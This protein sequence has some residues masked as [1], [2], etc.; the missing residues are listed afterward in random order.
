MSEGSDSGIERAFGLTPLQEGMLYHSVRQPGSGLYH[1]RSTLRLRGPLDP[2]AFRRAW[3]AA[4]ARHEAFRTIFAWE[5]LERPLQVVLTE[6][7]LE[8]EWLDW[9]ALPVGERERRWTALL[10]R[11]RSTPFELSAPPLMRLYVV[12]ETDGVHRLLWSVHHAVMDG[13]SAALVVGEVL[14]DYEAALAGEELS[15]ATAP[16]FAHFV[17]W[18]EAQDTE[19]AAAFW[20]HRLEG[21]TRATPLP[22][23]SLGASADRAHRSL[24]LGA[25]A[26]E[27]LVAA[28][29]RMRVTLS[30]MVSAAWACVLART[31]GEGDVVYGVTLSERPA[32]IPGI[33]RAAGLYLSTVPVRVRLSDSG[34]VG[35]WLRTLQREQ[36][37]E[38]A[39]GFVGLT[40]IR[41][42]APDLVEDAWLRTLVV[43]EGF[44]EWVGR[45]TPGSLTVS[46]LQVSGPSDL[47]LALLAYPGDALELQLVYDTGAFTAE[48]VDG[49]L[50][51][52]RDVLML[53]TSADGSVGSLFATAPA[54][55]EDAPAGSGASGETVVLDGGPLDRPTPDVATAVRA[56]ATQRPDEPALVTDERSW[57]YGTL[58][59]ATER[60]AERLRAEV[61]EGAIIGVVGV[62]SPEM[63]VAMLAALEASCSYVPIDAGLPAARLAEI[64]A[65]ATVLVGAEEDRSVVEAVQR[66]Y[67][68][69]TWGADARDGDAAIGA[70]PQ[71]AEPD[72]HEAAYVLFT[73]GSTGAPKGV[74]VERGQLAWSTAVRD[75]YYADP[76]SCFLLLSPLTVDSSVAGVYW[77]LTNGGALVL[78]RRRA[79]QDPV[80]L[81]KLVDRAGV[82]HML[83]LPSLY[84]ALL[85]HVDPA[86]LS[87]LR[88]VVV[89]GEACAEEVVRTH[90]ER[91]PDARLFNE[92]GPAEATVWATAAELTPGAEVSIGRPLPGVRIHL[93]PADGPTGSGDGVAEIHIAGSG[94]ARGYLDRPELTAERFAPE[95]GRP[96]SRMYRTGD[97]ARLLPDGALAFA[98]RA[99]EQ[100]K[101]RGYRV[102]ALEV[103]GA[104]RD[105]PSVSDALV[106]LRGGAPPVDPASDEALVDALA[107]LPDREV[108]ALFAR[109]GGVR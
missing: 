100:I 54:G 49:L 73:S 99:D 5:R 89:A 75:A 86:M 41:R 12:R 50:V 82:S 10:E 98:G 107:T 58:W 69:V 70:R 79:E 24:S 60:L 88:T 84:H 37:E 25:A 62:R 30:T 102:E 67:L 105:H 83:L 85:E 109:V 53:L 68:T 96:G 21:V 20:R 33:E 28:A 95:P 4:V 6:A 7:V 59:S 93:L 81:A 91:L 94:V 80:A 78:P 26:T 64:A 108:E 15:R 1:G 34:S 101:V 104:L 46:E 23:R 19:Q 61:G 52:V 2:D 45:S 38:R 97:L 92:Y 35:H 14:A 29:G 31:S 39:H 106:V 8:P 55:A 16:S 56:V 72:P 13:W 71:R 51:E 65:H 76:P 90:H 9:S 87:T 18:L 44:P 48:A 40:A 36:S 77:T 47:P 27:T 11:D 57:S 66:R 103:E 63:I 32:E 42:A 43:F 22:L 74:V 3:A 17:G